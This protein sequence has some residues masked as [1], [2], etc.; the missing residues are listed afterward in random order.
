MG[1]EATTPSRVYIHRLQK[2]EQGPVHRHRARHGLFATRRSPPD[3]AAWRRRRYPE[4][5]C[6]K[7]G[8][9]LPCSVEILDWMPRR[10]C[11]LADE[12]RAD[13][14]VTQN[15]ANKPFPDRELGEMRV[16]ANGGTAGDGRRHTGC[17]HGLPTAPPNP[18][19]RP[20][21]DI[22]YQVLGLRGEAAQRSACR[23]PPPPWREEPGAR[24]HFRDGE[25]N[26]NE[27]RIGYTR[28][29]LPGYTARPTWRWWVGETL[30]KRSRLATEIIK[31]D[32][33]VRDPAAGRA[34]GLA[35]AGAAS[36]RSTSNAAAHPPPRQQRPLADRRA[37]GAGGCRRW[38]ARDQRPA[39]AARPV[40]RPTRST[41]PTRRNERCWPGCAPAELAQR[42][43][44]AA[45]AA[46]E[47]KSL[48]QIAHPARA[49]RTWSTSCWRWRA[50]RTRS[51]R[52]NARPST[53][54][55]WPPR[56]CDF[57][58]RAH[59][60]RI[61]LGYEGPETGRSAPTSRRPLVS[62]NALRC[63]S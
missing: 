37:R 21:D 46:S 12:R 45:S 10:C 40:D 59:G 15:I 39:G 49:R 31:G 17:H 36:R 4:R 9:A 35:G 26:N 32:P 48:Q 58:P 38:C 53:W 16:L 33:A 6:C 18:A 55:G 41:S 5:R 57:V 62:G 63:A 3:P 20:E 56:R 61:D 27:L 30:G 24:T 11:L 25:I 50:P 42:E 28:G 52:R 51:S 43:I 60:K 44:D 1:E 23:V 47:L 14:W 54:R 34:A 7:P 29:G 13:G 8:T 2:I 19:H 22:Y